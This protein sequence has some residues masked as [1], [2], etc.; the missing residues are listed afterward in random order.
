M[1]TKVF[2]QQKNLAFSNT[3][4]L[5]QSIVIVIVVSTAKKKVSYRQPEPMTESIE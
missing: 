2:S 4:E 5:D 3:G 1:H